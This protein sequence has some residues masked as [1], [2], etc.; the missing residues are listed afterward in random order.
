MKHREMFNGRTF[1]ISEDPIPP[2]MGQRVEVE[3]E[4]PFRGK[5]PPAGSDGRSYYPRASVVKRAS[6]TSSATEAQKLSKK[7][8]ALKG[9]R[10]GKK[11]R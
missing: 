9:R 6:V 10:H 3:V 5:A 8:R 11:G 7:F 4:A 2:I 1:Y